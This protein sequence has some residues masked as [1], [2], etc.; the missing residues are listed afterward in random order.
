M[1]WYPHWFSICGRKTEGRVIHVSLDKKKKK[2]RQ[3]APDVSSVAGLQ[4]IFTWS[5]IQTA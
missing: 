4:R 3:E 1:R 5:G 2:H